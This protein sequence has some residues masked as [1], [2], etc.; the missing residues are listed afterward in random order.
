LDCYNKVVELPYKNNF[1]A[2]S[3]FRF[4][5]KIGENKAPI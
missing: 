5:I 1:V 2:E 3:R 4:H